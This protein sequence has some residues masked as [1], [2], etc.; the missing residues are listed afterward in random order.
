M[1]LL[2]AITMWSTFTPGWRFHNRNNKHIENVY[3]PKT[4]CARKFACSK[5]FFD[6][7]AEATINVLSSRPRVICASVRLKNKQIRFFFHVWS[8][9]FFL[10]RLKNQF[11]I[12]LDISMVQ[13]G[14]VHDKSVSMSKHGKKWWKLSRILATQSVLTRF[15]ELF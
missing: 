1:E 10:Q 8:T 15:E 5:R 3:C 4:I 6:L 14:A 7:S 11:K 9:I 13:V 2:R 12:F